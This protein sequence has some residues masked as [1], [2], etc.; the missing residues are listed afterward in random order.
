M[1]KYTMSLCSTWH[2]TTS[3]SHHVWAGH[4]TPWDPCT[5]PHRSLQCY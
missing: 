2:G 1:L 3:R 4:V 5:W